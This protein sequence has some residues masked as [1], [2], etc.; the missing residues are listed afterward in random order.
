VGPECQNSVEGE[1]WE[2]KVLLYP[3]W[4]LGIGIGQEGRDKLTLSSS[5]LYLPLEPTLWNTHTHNTH[6][7]KQKTL[8]IVIGLRKQEC[9]EVGG[10]AQSDT[11]RNKTSPLARFPRSPTP[12]PP[13]VQGNSS[14]F[15]AL[16]HP[17]N[18][19]DSRQ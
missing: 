1:T 13:L 9:R 19:R 12:F 16:L 4:R 17:S 10:P 6:T 15:S 2:P 8:C 18:L 14:C 3:P 5:S 11:E 7:H